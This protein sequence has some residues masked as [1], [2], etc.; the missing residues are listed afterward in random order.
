MC[1]TIVEKQISLEK[2]CAFVCAYPCGKVI[3]R[4]NGREGAVSVG[5]KK[6][7]V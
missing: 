5:E 4:K 6:L 2:K 1:E 3:K 7:D